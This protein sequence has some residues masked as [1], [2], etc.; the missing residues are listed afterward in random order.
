MLRFCSLYS[1]STGNCLLV[2]DDQTKILV[3]AG[4]S[5]KKVVE[6]LASLQIDMSQISAILVTHEH[7]DHIKSIGTLSKK[8]NIPVFANQETWQAMPK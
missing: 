5:G 7:N 3:D 2:Q 1:G 6:A 4:V 8:Y